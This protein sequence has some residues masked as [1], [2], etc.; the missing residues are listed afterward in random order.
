MMLMAM[1]DKLHIQRP[2]ML[3]S[4]MSVPRPPK[5]PFHTCLLQVTQ[6]QIR[7]ATEST[8]ASPGP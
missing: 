6:T 8:Q 1:A 7:T 3:S 5:P 2:G 4:F